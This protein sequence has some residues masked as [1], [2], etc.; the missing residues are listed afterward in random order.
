MA[1][2]ESVKIADLSLEQLVQLQQGLGRDIDKLREQRVYLA[3]KIADRLAAGDRTS[4]DG[5]AAAP[6]ATLQVSNG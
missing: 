5:D 1:N 2:T 6:G 3:K 4:T